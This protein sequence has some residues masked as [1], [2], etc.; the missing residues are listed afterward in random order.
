MFVISLRVPNALLAESD[1]WRNPVAWRYLA[2]D[3][4]S[5]Y[6]R[7]MIGSRGHWGHYGQW[8]R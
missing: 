4:D 5:F 3:R 6:H 8:G 2:G 1:H 7:E